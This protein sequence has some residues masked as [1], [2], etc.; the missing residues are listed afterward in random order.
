M[1]PGDASGKRAC[2]AAVKRACPYSTKQ[3]IA[4]N[5]FF[6]GNDARRYA[7]ILRGRYREEDI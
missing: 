7:A 4:C 1:V 2:A 5:C 6:G 3:T